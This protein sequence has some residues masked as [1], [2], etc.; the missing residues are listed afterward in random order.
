MALSCRLAILHMKRVPSDPVSL[1]LLQAMVSAKTVTYLHVFTTKFNAGNLTVYGILDWTKLGFLNLTFTLDGVSEPMSFDISANSAFFQQGGVVQP[2]LAFYQ[3]PT[4]A[5]SNGQHTLV[6]DLVDSQN[7]TFIL[8][9]VT[10]APTASSTHT[11][12]SHAGTIV[13]GVVGGLSLLVLSFVVFDCVI[14]RRKRRNR[15]SSFSAC[16]IS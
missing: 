5:S 2:N 12:K 11:K 1:I 14:L 16:F 15:R 3:S 6:V 9:Y 8:D 7:Q 4:N 13:G 10:F